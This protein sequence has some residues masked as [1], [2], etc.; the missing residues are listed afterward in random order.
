MFFNGPV[1]SLIP[2]GQSLS[3]Q[4]FASTVD[5]DETVRVTALRAIERKHEA[6]DIDRKVEDLDRK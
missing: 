3:I 1:P 5:R 4:F 6:K 2:P